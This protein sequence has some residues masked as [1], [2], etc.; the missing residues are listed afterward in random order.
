MGFTYSFCFLFGLGF[1]FR[2]V[3]YFQC[4]INKAF[5]SNEKVYF[6]SCSSFAGWSHLSSGRGS[7]FIVK[8]PVWIAVWIFSTLIGA[9]RSCVCTNLECSCHSLVVQCQTVG[10]LIKTKPPSSSISLFI[11]NQRGSVVISGLGSRNKRLKQKPAAWQRTW[12]RFDK[13]QTWEQ[14]VHSFKFICVTEA[15]WLI[16]D[17]KMT[18]NSPKT[19]N[20]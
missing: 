10:T 20:K 9:E 19:L 1:K 15:F 17:L 7:A 14:T 13:F 6:A 4:L 3:R 2:P 12:I 11:S 18:L 5:F 8:A 16:T